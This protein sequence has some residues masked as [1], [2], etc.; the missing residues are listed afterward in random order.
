MI[1]CKVFRILSVI[2]SE[3]KNHTVHAEILPVGQNDKGLHVIYFTYLN[4][5]Q[6]EF[7]LYKL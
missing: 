4:P 6:K 5:H 2:L 3:A 1:L 7:F